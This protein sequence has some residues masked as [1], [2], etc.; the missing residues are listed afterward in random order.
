M[1]KATMSDGDSTLTR[2]ATGASVCY[3]C[4]M[5]P[6]G[7]VTRKSWPKINAL[8]TTYIQMYDVMRLKRLILKKK[9]KKMFY[10]GD[11]R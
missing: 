1:E 6:P 8:I 11:K 10:C 3:H 9:K 2:A 4:Y 5:N 7:F